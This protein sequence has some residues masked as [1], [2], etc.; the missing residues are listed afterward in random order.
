M[1]QYTEQIVN[2]H[3][4]MTKQS[5]YARE[6]LI[7]AFNNRSKFNLFDLGRNT[8]ST[9]QRKIQQPTA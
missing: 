8:R 9:A 2:G 7:H 6:I 5:Y 4:F 3:N 1:V